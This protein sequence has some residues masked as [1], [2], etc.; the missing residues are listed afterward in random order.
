MVLGIL[1]GIAKIGIRATKVISKSA[2]KSM[3]L[4]LDLKSIQQNAKLSNPRLTNSQINS[5][6]VGIQHNN[7]ILFRK[8]SHGQDNLIPY[9]LTGKKTFTTKF[10][11]QLKNQSGE[12]DTFHTRVTVDSKMTIAQIKVLTIDQ[13]RNSDFTQ[14]G[15]IGYLEGDAIVLS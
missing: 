11:V 3:K 14:S 7:P 15:K 5:V 6:V 1:G 10:K 13:I 2:V 9:N 4:N 12:I 8:W